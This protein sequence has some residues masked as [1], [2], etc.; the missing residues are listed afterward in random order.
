MMLLESTIDVATSEL[1]LSR[2]LMLELED[3]DEPVALDM[4]L[5]RLLD[6]IENELA[7]PV[8]LIGALLA[9]VLLVRPLL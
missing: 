1:L 6:K 3:E 5:A 9:I 2:E 8:A 7:R 4:T